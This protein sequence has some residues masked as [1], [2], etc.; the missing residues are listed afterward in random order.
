[1]KKNTA[2]IILPI[3]VVAIVSAILTF[4]KKNVADAPYRT[5]SGLVFGTSYNITYQSNDN[6]EADIK[7]VLDSVDISLSPFNKNS[8]ITAVNNNK[9]PEVNTYFT[10]VFNLAKKVYAETDG[11]FDITVAPLVNVW[12]F[13]FKKGHFPTDNE[14]DSL[15]SIVGFDKVRL[16]GKKVIKDDPRIMLDC[17]A[18]AKGFAVDKV[19]EM[20]KRHGVENFLVEIGGEIVA[21]GCNSKGKDWSIGVTKPVD[22]SL[23]V[24]SDM[25]MIIALSDCALATS[26]NYRNYYIKDGKKYAHTI[27]PQ[28]G[29][30]AESD[31]LSATVITNTCAEADAYAT[32]LMTLGRE[33]SLEILKRHQEIRYILIYDDNNMTSCDISKGLKHP[34]GTPLT[35]K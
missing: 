18:I 24:N 19:G 34:D 35:A 27:N 13:G 17:S 20:L 12:G 32:G 3:I 16:V 9:N 15:K 21:S 23:S 1:M 25:Q 5:A 10:E 14:V 29:R 8:I 33:K 26:G 7:A 4:G 30:P 22:D 6:Y 28:T 11:A 31:L 2:A